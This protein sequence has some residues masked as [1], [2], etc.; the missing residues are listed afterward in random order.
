MI[1]IR[2]RHN[3]VIPTMAQGVVEYKEAYG[4]DPVVSQNVQYFLDRFYMSRISIRMLLNQHSEHS[5]SSSPPPFIQSVVNFLSCR[6]RV[7]ENKAI[8]GRRQNVPLTGEQGC[9]FPGHL[10]VILVF[11]QTQT[12]YLQPFQQIN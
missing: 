11:F 5:F 1:K 10:V 7:L 12:G 8:R 6:W 4:T 9:A 2:N 3:D